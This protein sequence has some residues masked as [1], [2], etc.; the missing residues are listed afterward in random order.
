[1][2][3]GLEENEKGHSGTLWPSGPSDELPVSWLRFRS[4]L[5]L[6]RTVSHH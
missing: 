3:G 2:I 5:W 6:M 1:L 4:P